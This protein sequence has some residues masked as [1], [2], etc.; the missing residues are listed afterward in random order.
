MFLVF[1]ESF[2]VLCCHVFVRVGGPTLFPEGGRPTHLGGSRR[3]GAM[4]R[5][6][7]T[8]AL[9]L[10]VFGAWDPLQIVASMGSAER[11]TSFYRPMEIVILAHGFWTR[12][13][14]HH[15]HRHP[16]ATGCDRQ[17]VRRQPGGPPR[18]G[19]QD[20]RRSVGLHVRL[21]KAFQKA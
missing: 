10:S 6:A 8:G 7:S 2:C 9:S 15:R 1:L 5:R 3:S 14:R 4:F 20:G 12:P 16:P 11:L 19:A 17:S 21:E 18:I 13:R